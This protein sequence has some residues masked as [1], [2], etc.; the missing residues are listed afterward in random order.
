LLR[1]TL[2]YQ[3]VTNPGY[4]RDRGPASIIGTRLRAQF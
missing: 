3:F 2:D 1:M 4:N